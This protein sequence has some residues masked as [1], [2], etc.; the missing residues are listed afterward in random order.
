MA[1]A[2]AFPAAASADNTPAGP[3]TLLNRWTGAYAP[4]GPLARGAGRGGGVVGAG[5]QAGTVRPRPSGRRAA[6]TPST[7]P[8]EPGTYRF[9]APHIRWDYRG[10]Q[11]GLDQETGD[12]A[13]LTQDA[14][15]PA[16]GRAA[17]R[18]RS[19]E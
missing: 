3:A 9:P 19:S 17:I 1:L 16:L 7:L 6:A 12:H 4:P 5:G 13:I 8:A 15:D 2:L 14:C 11:I 18:A 10:S